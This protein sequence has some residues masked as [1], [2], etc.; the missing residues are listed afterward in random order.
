MLIR[1]LR[2]YSKETIKKMNPAAGT[3]RAVTS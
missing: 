2:D 3:L 1:D